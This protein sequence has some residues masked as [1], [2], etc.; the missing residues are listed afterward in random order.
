MQDESEVL[1]RR[2]HSAG[3]TVV[4]DGHKGMPHCF[5]VVPWTQRGFSALEKWGAFC[6][7]PPSCKA[8]ASWT[9]KSGESTKVD[10]SELGMSDGRSLDDTAVEK[11]MARERER[12]IIL[13]QSLIERWK[14]ES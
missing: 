1:A 6:Q 11:L 7:D 5:A 8:S 4:F 13:E 10:L 12:R 2:L 9:K 3:A 14:M